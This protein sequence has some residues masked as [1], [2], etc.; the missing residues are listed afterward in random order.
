[1]VLEFVFGEIGIIDRNSNNLHV[2]RGNI[3]TGYVYLDI[4]IA[5]DIKRIT[6]VIF[7][8]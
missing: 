2:F 5:I 8:L 3:D 4:E 6:S 1:M 7:F